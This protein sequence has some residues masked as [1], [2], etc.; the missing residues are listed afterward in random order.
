MSRPYIQTLAATY[1]GPTLSLDLEYLKLRGNPGG[2]FTVT[3]VSS[4]AVSFS[5]TES[6]NLSKWYNVAVTL[7]PDGAV[8]LGGSPSVYLYNGTLTYT[9]TGALTQFDTFTFSH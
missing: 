9:T 7:N 3:G 1:A 5:V 2:T 4:S 6:N 8:S